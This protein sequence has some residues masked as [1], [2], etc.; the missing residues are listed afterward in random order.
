MGYPGD[1]QQPGGWG[2]HRSP[3]SPYGP[4]EDEAEPAGRPPY[5][6][7]RDDS[8]YGLPPSGSPYE[9]A[10]PPSPYGGS[11]YDDQ[12]PS[13]PPYG[14]YGQNPYEQGP[15]E[16][17]R[18]DGN[19]Y[20]SG[21]FYGGDGPSPH[22]EDGSPSGSG[23]KRLVIGAAVAAG[24]IVVGGTAVALTSGG[25]KK[26]A[27]PPPPPK[28][29]VTPTPRPTPT[30][31]GTGKGD[32]LQ[33]RATD[34]HLLT[35]N[36]VF[37][38]RTFKAGG[39]SYL[40]TMR[41]HDRKCSSGAHGTS[42]RKALARGGCVQVLRATF[43]NGKLIGT[44]GI[45]NLRTQ[46]AAIAA[47]TA[48]RPKDAFITPLPGS[49]GITKKIGQGLSLTTAEADGH[50]LIMSWVQYPDGK[51]ITKSDYS[52]VSAFVRNTTLGSNLRPALNYRSMEGK[53][54]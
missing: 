49:S 4:A 27:G 41:R 19:S 11:P 32:L 16:Q 52:A 53:P 10:P 23:K 35:L 18:Y 43:S 54:S 13:E 26:P 17:D 36:E 2:S 25:G 15:Y 50:Y 51:K 9:D 38:V 24:L 5:G 1:Q 39:R 28:A 45:I 30:A 7:G 44:I 46:A 47:Q 34:P 8:P 12:Y 42:F 29:A 3:Q 6:G 33:S 14:E 48:S 22:G 21:P 20:G 40:M 37:K 31:T